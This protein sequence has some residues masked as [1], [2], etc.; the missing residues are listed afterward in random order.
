MTQRRG[1]WGMRHRGNDEDDFRK[2][3]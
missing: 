3:R 1:T 2:W